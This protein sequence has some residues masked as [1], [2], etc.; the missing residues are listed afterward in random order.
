MG[1]PEGVPLD[2]PLPIRSRGTAVDDDP[3][4]HGGV[5]DEARRIVGELSRPARFAEISARLNWSLGDDAKRTWAKYKTFKAF[6]E[7]AVP[8]A[9]ILTDRPP[10]WVYPEGVPLDSPTTR[11]M[12]RSAGSR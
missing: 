6:L 10:G 3:G 1:L 4:A 11:H 2:H 8:T 7:Y 12:V 9:Q 5:A